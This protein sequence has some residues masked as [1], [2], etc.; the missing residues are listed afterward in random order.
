MSVRRNFKH[1]CT[2]TTP[3]DTVTGKNKYQEPIYGSNTYP[4]VPCQI[5]QQSSTVDEADRK[6]AANNYLM[7]IGYE[8]DITKNSTVVFNKPG[9]TQTVTTRVMGDPIPKQLGYRISHLEVSL[10]EAED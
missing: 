7:L 1:L 3:S 8:I 5:T 9:T 6:T 10:A 2:V 4:D